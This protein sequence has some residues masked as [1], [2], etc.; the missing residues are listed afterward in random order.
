MYFPANS[1]GHVG[2]TNSTSSLGKE[3]EKLF[4]LLEDYEQYKR[5]YADNFK[6][7]PNE[8]DLSMQNILNLNDYIFFF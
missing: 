1:W 3:K 8:K 5:E 2:K 7:D 4:S 6:F